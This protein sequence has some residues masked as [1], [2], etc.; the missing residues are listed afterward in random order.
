MITPPS[1]RPGQQEGVRNEYDSQIGP[2]ETTGCE[3]V[4][5]NQEHN[6]DLT[7]LRRRHSQM[8]RARGRESRYTIL[9]GYTCTVIHAKSCRPR[10]G[11]VL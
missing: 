10:D 5:S 9:V 2:S 11:S 3:G 1:I 6:I 8:K 4:K 7:A